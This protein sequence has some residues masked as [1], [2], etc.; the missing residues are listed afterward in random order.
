MIIISHKLNEVA[1]VADKITV[2]RDGATIETIDNRGP[3][4][5]S[6]ERII[7]GMVGREMTNR[8]PKRE[9]VTVGDIQLEVDN[10]TVHHPLYPERKVVDNVSMY[11]R[12]GEV[13]GIYGLMGA[14][15]TE[16]AMSIFGQTYGVNISGT[17]KID[18]KEV[19]I[20]DSSMEPAI[21]SGDTYL[22][23]SLIYHISAPK[24][25][26]IIVFRTE[27]DNGSCLHVKRVIGLPGETIQIEDGQVKI[28]G[29]TYVGDDCPTILNA[30]LAADPVT[31]TDNEYFV[32]GDNRNGSE[33]SR[34]ASIGNVTEDEITGKIWL[35]VPSALI[36][37]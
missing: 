23:N 6:E 2:V 26:D 34:S 32:L 22:I 7:K 8:F 35:R 16:L 37:H 28:N 31:L 4:P 14:G 10:W 13:V 24:R 3:E 20:S 27:S 15:R 25:G 19:K 5:V 11:V 18:G 12:K 9:G 30:G 1:Y 21:S 17:M 29:Q 36:F 33:D